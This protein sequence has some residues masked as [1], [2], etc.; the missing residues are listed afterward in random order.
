MAAEA[1]VSKLSPEERARI[2]TQSIAHFR[3]PSGPDLL[4]RTERFYDYMQSRAEY[5]LWPYSRAL[6]KAAGPHTTVSDS[7]TTTREGIN[8]ASQDY[9]GLSRH[10]SI[11]AAGIEAMR[12]FG[13]HSAGSA[14]LLGNT[15]LSLELEQHLA[16]LLGMEHVALYPT[17]WAAGYGAIAAFV[18]PRDH[19]VIDHQCHACLQQGAAAATPQINHFIHNDAVDLKA[20]LAGIRAKDARNG[21]MV[22][23][24]GLFSV[25][26]ESPDLAA[27]QAACSE[28]G[29]TLLVDVA[30]DLGALGPG[31][32]GMLAAQGLLGKV[33]LVMG[34]F[35]KTFASNGGFLASR[36]P[37]VKQFAKYYGNPH[38]FSNA[39][40]P[41]QAA[42]VVAGHPHRPLAGGRRR[43]ARACW[44][45]P[46][47]C[48]MALPRRGSHVSARRRRSCSCPSA[49][50]AWPAWPR[51]GSRRAACSSISWNTRPCRSTKRA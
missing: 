46:M 50:I 32:G 12:E 1:S 5:G 38:M 9:L 35:A 7:T 15:R 8:F 18:R 42:V 31:G 25:D 39:L 34:S 16:A 14:V 21:I 40:S 43:C 41:V 44:P 37:A 23:T 45:A 13:P 49:T 33:D 30:H 51:A 27:F 11:A 17:G 29:A 2:M 28:F 47:P 4:K 20:R 3:N 19:I 10:P 22:I 36:S 26:S 48:A 24:E 6:E